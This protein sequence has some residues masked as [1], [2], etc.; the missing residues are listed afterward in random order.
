MPAVLFSGCYDHVNLFTERLVDL[1][2]LTPSSLGTHRMVTLCNHLFL[3]WEGNRL[4]GQ[5]RT[6][7]PV[8]K[9]LPPSR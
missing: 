3:C 9:L 2:S 5:N 4:W 7:S 6:E 1:L 8:T